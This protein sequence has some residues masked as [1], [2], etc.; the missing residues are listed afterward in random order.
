[1]VVL[2]GLPLVVLWIGV[3]GVVG[4]DDCSES[5]LTSTSESSK[6]VSRV[7]GEEG[8]LLLPLGDACLRALGTRFGVV[9]AVCIVCVVC[10]V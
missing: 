6:A 9:C 3:C 8:L 10:V 7:C 1:M 5:V 2:V 4:S